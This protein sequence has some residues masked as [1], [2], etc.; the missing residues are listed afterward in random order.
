MSDT[1]ILREKHP[2][3]AEFVEHWRA[4]YQRHYDF[5]KTEDQADFYEGM[6]EIAR[7]IATNGAG[8]NIT[9]ATST[10]GVSGLNV[11]VSPL[12]SPSS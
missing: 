9:V 2:A 5:S 3:V 1:T 7:H 12:A 10:S 6:L 11:S 8:A 4:K